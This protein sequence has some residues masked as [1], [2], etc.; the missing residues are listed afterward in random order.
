[1]GR[2]VPPQSNTSNWTPSSIGIILS[3]CGEG[4]C[5]VFDKAVCARLLGPT[6]R[7]DTDNRT[8]VLTSLKDRFLQTDILTHI[9]FSALS[10]T[11]SC[12]LWLNQTSQCKSRLF[13]L[14]CASIFGAMVR[15]T[16]TER[17]QTIPAKTQ[18]DSSLDRAPLLDTDTRRVQ[19]SA[20]AASDRLVLLL[21]D[22]PA[23]AGPESLAHPAP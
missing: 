23:N 12:C 15:T 22:F 18:R 13:R 5:Q 9:E 20:R 7:A 19:R 14:G 3:W 6:L 11:H 1:M 21:V 17:W 8:T 16:L 4:S 2:P 10:A